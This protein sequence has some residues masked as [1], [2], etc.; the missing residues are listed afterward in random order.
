MEQPRSGRDMNKACGRIEM[1]CCEG[2]K[3]TDRRTEL[4]HGQDI[5]YEMK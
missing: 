2:D 5:T 1:P 4:I 3:I